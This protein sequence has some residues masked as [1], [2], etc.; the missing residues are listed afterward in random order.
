MQKFLKMMNKKISTDYFEETVSI[1]KEAEITSLTSVVFG[2]PIETKETIRK[3]FDMCYRNNIYP[4]IG[5]PS[6]TPLYWYV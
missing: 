5:F 3:T 6:A 4:S 1:L 2:Y